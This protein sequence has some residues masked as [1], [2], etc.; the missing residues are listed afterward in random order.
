MKRHCY[1]VKHLMKSYL[2]NMGL[3][4]SK[5]PQLPPM[6][7]EQT[8]MPLFFLALFGEKI[9]L[10]DNKFRKKDVLNDSTTNR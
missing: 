2:I 9:A 7:S 3:P 1:Q 8:F 4:Q 5:I 6:S 10:L